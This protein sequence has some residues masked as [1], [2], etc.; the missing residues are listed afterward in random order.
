MPNKGIYGKCQITAT[1]TISLKGISFPCKLFTQGKQELGLP[2]FELPSEFNIKHSPNHWSNNG[3]G[4]RILESDPLFLKTING[5]GRELWFFL[6]FYLANNHFIFNMLT[7]NFELLFNIYIF[8]EKE[9][10]GIRKKKKC[11]PLNGL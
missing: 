6:N 5:F 8:R 3:E 11:L 1:V 7:I 2:K 9:N 10:S 4:S